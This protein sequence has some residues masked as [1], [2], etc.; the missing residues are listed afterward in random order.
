MRVDQ[1]KYD[2]P[3]DRIAQHPSE[4][5][6][7][8]KLMVLRAKNALEHHRVGDLADLI[9]ENSLVVLNDTRVMPARLIAQKDTG[10]R[11]EVFLVRLVTGRTIEALGETR[12]A[13]IWRALGK[14]SK[15]LRFGVDM[16]VM[17]AGESTA[18]PSD[19]SLYVRLRGRG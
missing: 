4:E 14:A 18:P 17:P 10:G 12:D 8:A 2:L 16:R 13:Q 1:L 9:P 3:P 5:R 7:H 15:A 6:E 19:G 11:V